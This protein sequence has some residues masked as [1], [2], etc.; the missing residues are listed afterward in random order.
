MNQAP[1]A[2]QIPQNKAAHFIPHSK[3]N[4]IPPAQSNALPFSSKKKN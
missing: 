1:F 2:L 3:A 4:F